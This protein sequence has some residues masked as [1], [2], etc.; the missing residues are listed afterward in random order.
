MLKARPL[1]QLFGLLTI[2]VGSVLPSNVVVESF[3]LEDLEDWNGVVVNFLVRNRLP[4]DRYKA[5]DVQ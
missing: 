4:I 3:A 5:C 1:T 2:P